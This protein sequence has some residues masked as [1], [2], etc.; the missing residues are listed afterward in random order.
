MSEW[1][2]EREN[3]FSRISLRLREEI[4]GDEQSGP[5]NYSAEDLNT[6]LKDTLSDPNRDKEQDHLEA[7]IR[8]NQ[9]A[10]EFD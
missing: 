6:Y 8:P 5:L 2:S 10:T 3:I 4:L 9:P 7:I 1:K